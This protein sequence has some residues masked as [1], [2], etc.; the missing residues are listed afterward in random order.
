MNTHFSVSMSSN[1][2]LQE[3]ISFSHNPLWCSS[4]LQTLVQNHCPQTFFKNVILNLTTHF[5]NSTLTWLVKKINKPKN[6]LTKCALMKAKAVKFK[7]GIFRIVIKNK[8][9]RVLKKPF[10]VMLDIF[11]KF[12]WLFYNR[13]YFSFGKTI[14]RCVSPSRDLQISLVNNVYF[15]IY[16]FVY[17]GW[18]GRFKFWNWN[19]DWIWVYFG[20]F[21][22]A[23]FFNDCFI[24]RYSLT[25]HL[26]FQLPWKMILELKYAS[27]LW[28]SWNCHQDGV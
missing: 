14:L 18:G 10:T 11:F 15:I 25:S 13:V 16:F 26:G 17:L 7:I 22:E 4:D 6:F 12:W 2:L 3:K 19:W 24:N 23:F 28:S 5:L 9:W 20:G 8:V 1:L 21:F 27:E